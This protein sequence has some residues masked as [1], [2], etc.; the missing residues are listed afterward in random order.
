[1]TDDHTDDDGARGDASASR[2]PLSTPEGA[3]LPAERVREVES[4]VTDWLHDADVP[5]TSVV[6]VD[7]DGVR[8]AEGFGARDVETNAP[9]TPDTLYPVGSVTKAVTSLAVLQLVE[10]GHLA[11]EDPV[12]EYVPHFADA[13]GAPITVGELLSHT[14]GMPSTLPTFLAQHSEGDPA[15]VADRADFERWV[16][17]TTDYRVT[18][19]DRFFYYGTG[20][21]VLGLVIEAVDGRPYADYVGEEVLAPL[22]MDRSTFERDPFESDDD[23][24]TGYSQGEDGLE[25]TSFPFETLM[26]PGGGLVSSPRELSRFLR[27]TMT[28]GALDG[29]RLCSPETLDRLQRGRAT[30]TTHL[31]GSEQ[32][33]GFGWIRQPFGDDEL[34]WHGGAIPG[35]TAFAGVLDGGDLGV[36]V[37]CNTTPSPAPAEIGKRILAILTGTDRTAV[38]AV[39][40]REKCEMVTGTYE[41]YH[42]GTVT[43]ERDHGGIA[44]DLGYPGPGDDE[45]VTAYPTSLDPDDHDFYFVAGKGERMPVEFDLGGDRADLYFD[46][47]RFRRTRP[48]E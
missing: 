2:P 16:R 9:A 7:A 3:A 15:G 44:I 12:D 31:D 35:S 1:M 22:G 37:A 28:D 25:P 19:G 24:I 29:V 45:R 46:R 41:H 38:P 47:H 8:Y 39:A 17:D 6:V 23:A 26:Q 11:V 34:V 10:D 33:Y 40:I 14:S 32:E 36:V 13:P 20:Y 18:D 5:G 48:G 4:L 43:V 30:R 42:R 27:A 21:S